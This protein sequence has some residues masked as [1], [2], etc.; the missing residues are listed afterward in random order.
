MILNLLW[1]IQISRTRGKCLWFYFIVSSSIMNFKINSFEKLH[2]WKWSKELTPLI[3]PIKDACK[4]QV[5]CRRYAK[6]RRKQ[7]E[8]VAPNPIFIALW[9]CVLLRSFGWC[10]YYESRASNKFIIAIVMKSK[11]FAVSSMQEKRILLLKVK[12]VLRFRFFGD[13][14]KGKK[15]FL[16]FIIHSRKESCWKA[17]T[18]GDE[19]EKIK[20]FPKDISNNI[21]PNDMECQGLWKFA[22]LQASRFDVFF[23]GEEM[24]IVEEEVRVGTNWIAMYTRW[25]K[26]A[27]FNHAQIKVE[28][29]CNV[30]ETKMKK[31]PR[32]SLT[33][34]QWMKG[35]IPTAMFWDYQ[36][37]WSPHR[38]SK[39]WIAK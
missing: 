21:L 19:D 9:R 23:G 12:I 18:S 34:N 25:N 13:D 5:T 2:R 20:H 15:S 36:N 8:C 30:N 22:S 39:R 6:H 3:Q 24:R 27:G 29:L 4:N 7:A 35:E 32:K 16:S 38:I 31:P 17:P 10:L 28:V 1:F 26:Q 14:F 33:R 11:N 37:E